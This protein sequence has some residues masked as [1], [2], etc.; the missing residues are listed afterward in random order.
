MCIQDE[1]RCLFPSLGKIAVFTI[2]AV[3][4]EGIEELKYAIADVVEQHR[5]IQME[6]E[7]EAP[8]K[9]KPHYPPPASAARGRAR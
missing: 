2:S 5:P 7:T 4:G 1:G 9:L 3:T 8:A 6:P